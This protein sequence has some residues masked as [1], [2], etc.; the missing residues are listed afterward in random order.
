ME[1][2]QTKFE[3]SLNPKMPVLATPLRLLRSNFRKEGLT[4]VYSST[5]AEKVG[6]TVSRMKLDDQIHTTE[7]EGKQEVKIRALNPQ[8]HIFQLRICPLKIL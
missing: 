3:Q 1:K 8:G 2:P 4:L 6:K 7:A 5:L